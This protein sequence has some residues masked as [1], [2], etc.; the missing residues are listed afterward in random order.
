MPTIG[1]Y[2]FPLGVL[3]AGAMTQAAAQ[4][5][6]PMTIN[7]FSNQITTPSGLTPG[8]RGE[9]FGMRPE[10]VGAVSYF[11]LST[12]ATRSL[13]GGGGKKR[14][15]IALPGGSPVVCSLNQEVN[16]AGS[17]TLSGVPEG[18]GLAGNCN[19]VVE[20]GQVSGII[21]TLRG[22]YRIVPLGSGN[23]HAVVQIRTEAFPNEG[24]TLRK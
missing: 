17:V 4:G 9:A 18:G 11:A 3:V 1:S 22:R 7:L 2:R 15:R 5:A 21:D 24:P 23:A 14:V 13:R 19:L 16:S 10:T 12:E 6:P 8:S 20:N